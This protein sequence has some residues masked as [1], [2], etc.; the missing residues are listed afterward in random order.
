M[1]VIAD[2]PGEPAPAPPAP[3]LRGRASLRLAELERDLQQAREGLRFDLSGAFATALK[4]ERPVTVHGLK[5]RTNGDV[6]PVDLTVQRLH[7]PRELNGAVMIVLAD[8]TG[9]PEPAA[10][11]PKAHGR[12]NQRLAEME[13]EIQQSREEVQTIRE[14]MQTS[15][16]ELKSTNEEL[17]STNEELQSSNEELTT[18]KEEM[19]SMNEELQTV[20]QELQSK[21]DDL[22]HANNDM[23]NL[24]NSTQVATLFLDGE[25][26]VRRFTVQTTRIFKL[27]A[28]DIG[29][30]ITDIASGI[31]YPGMAEDARE[32]LR[33]LVFMEK[34]VPGT[35]GRWFTVRVMPYRTLENV[36]D[37]VVLTFADATAE[38]RLEESLHEQ[39]S[40]WRQMIESLP[41]LVQ[42]FRPDGSCDYLS[43]RWVE[44]TGVPEKDQT[45]YGW[46]EQ[47]HPD[48]RAR[49]LEQWKE[50]VRAGQ[51][52]QAR[53]R[54]RSGTGDHRWFKMSV[55]P[56][57]DEKGAIVQWYANC[58]DVDDLVRATGSGPGGTGG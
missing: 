41:A 26:H 25:L 50:S 22:A 37:G 16:E 53:L 19:Q 33:T 9:E 55:S 28:S 44:Y 46:L 1:I 24:L 56:T 2:A 54:I 32:V 3:A 12:A 35:D 10:P 57:R 27:I 5:V 18:S 52:L 7:E 34:Q 14:E 13:R 36:I 30:P 4:E 21:V 11:A 51:P 42:S 15:Q 17:Q 6:Q 40:Q 38:K 43:Q 48:D 39:A 29:R 23:R 47:V 49:I 58:A 45:G 20:N 8:A 31:D